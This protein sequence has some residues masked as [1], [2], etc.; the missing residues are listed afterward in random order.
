MIKR[1][2][3]ILFIVSAVILLAN[4][5]VGSLSSWDE[6]FYAQV[7]REIV[8]NNNWIDLTWMGNMWAD[9]PPVYFWSTA[10][11]YKIFGVNEFSARLFSAIAG[12]LLALIAYLFSCKMF[13]RRTGII[14]AIMLLSTYHFIWFSRMG[15]LDVTFTLFLFLSIF[16]FINAE[17]NRSNI[18]YFFLCFAV[19]FLTK[20]VGAILI[21]VILGMYVI[22]TKK[23]KVIASRN[24]AIGFLLFLLIA[25]SWYIIG[26]IRHGDPFLQGHFLQHLVQR[27][28]S[29]MDGHSGGWLTYINVVLYKGKPWGTLGLIILPIFIFYVIKERRDRAWVLVLCIVMTLLLFSLMGTKL[30]W[31]IMP[32]YPALAVVSAWGVDKLL[33]RFA[34]PVVIVVSVISLLYFGIKKDVYDLDL[35]PEIKS[36]SLKVDE[37]S[38][39]KNRKVY[40]YDLAD[41]G[42]RFYFGGIGEHISAGL[43]KAPSEFKGSIIV[44]QTGKIK[45]LGLEG[46]VIS[47][48]EG[49]FSAVIVK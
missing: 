40:L 32:V 23:W 20:G 44:S 13:S 46:E 25:G 3:I 35:N 19:A 16:F 36:F 49:R 43:S 45:A 2:L 10:C 6:A 4:L 48:E 12:I 27:T 9:K 38:A 8:E 17:E 1:D 47:S 41:P 33:K 5:G 26:F 18:I 15:T 7:S 34:L 14:A 24:A 29:A 39:S 42:M 22:V 21:P 11:F 31:Y 37:I 28:T 30:H